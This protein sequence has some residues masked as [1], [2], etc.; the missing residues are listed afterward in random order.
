[1]LLKKNSDTLFIYGTGSSLNNIS[2]TNYETI[3]KFDSVSINLFPN[4]KIHLSHYILGEGI[5]YLLYLFNSEKD[6]KAKDEYDSIINT[7]KTV[8]KNTNIIMI[9]KYVNS[10]TFLN[11]YYSKVK[12]DLIDLKDN[13]Y[14]VECG[15]STQTIEFPENHILKKLYHHNGSICCAIN[16]A[17]QM[18]YNKIVFAGVDLYNCLFKTPSYI[19]KKLYDNVDIVDVINDKH[20]SFKPIFNYLKYIKKSNNKINFYT[21]NPKSLLTKL[22]PIYKLE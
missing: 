8:Y 15:K 9:K 21:Y 16:Y 14:E 1:M 7:L 11:K 19:T 10:M 12:E 22:I 4:T 6:N 2:D 20:P 3:K 5:Y 17:I 18:K 13:I